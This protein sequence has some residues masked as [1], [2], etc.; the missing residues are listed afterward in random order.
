M[1]CRP[2][3]E[4]KGRL[5]S[6]I[7]ACRHDMTEEVPSTSG[8]APA[9]GLLLSWT[10]EHWFA[11]FAGVV[12]ALAIVL[13]IAWGWGTSRRLDAAL[14]DVRRRGEPLALADFVREDLPPSENAWA[15]Y[16]EAARAVATSSALPPSQSNC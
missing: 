11:A 6:A 9:K 4:P 1:D 3:P 2:V 12:V 14:D 10:R 13:R 5:Y 16:A 15:E 7:S 8:D